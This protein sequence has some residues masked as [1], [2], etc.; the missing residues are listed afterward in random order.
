MYEGR[1]SGGWRC[2]CRPVGRFCCRDRRRQPARAAAARRQA[3]PPTARKGSARRSTIAGRHPHL[4]GAS[5][6][7]KEPPASKPAGRRRRTG[8]SRADRRVRL[9]PQHALHFRASRQ[10]VRPH[11]VD[12]VR[13]ADRRPGRRRVRLPGGRRQHV[14][15]RESCTSSGTPAGRA[16][17]V[18]AANVRFV[19]RTAR[20]RER[21]DVPHQAPAAGG[22]TAE[23]RRRSCNRRPSRPGCG[24]RSWCRSRDIDPGHPGRAAVRHQTT[25]FWASPSYPPTAVPLMQRPAAGALARVQKKP[26]PRYG[27]RPAWCTT[28]YRPWAVTKVFWEAT[29]PHAAALRRQPGHRVEAQPRLRRGPDSV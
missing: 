23:P 19:R 12:R 15:R 2:R 8:G 24:R 29:P 26:S 25:T 27:L 9:G 5:A 28:P 22:G 1:A 11:R 4:P 20:R 17:E 21:P 3:R 6:Y 18:V 16:T 14:P 10:A 13:P 7:K